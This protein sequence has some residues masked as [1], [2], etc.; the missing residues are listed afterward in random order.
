MCTITAV[1]LDFYRYFVRRRGLWFT[2]RVLPLH[3]LYF[4]YCGCCVVWGTLLHYLT[5]DSVSASDPM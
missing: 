5:G 3:W 4:G 2:V 1:N